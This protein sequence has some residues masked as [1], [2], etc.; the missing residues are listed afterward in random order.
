VQQRRSSSPGTLTGGQR[1]G[2]RGWPRPP[3]S[4]CDRCGLLPVGRWWG[5][6]CTGLAVDGL[7]SPSD[8]EVGGHDI[9]GG[10]ETVVGCCK[11][12]VVFREEFDRGVC[13]RLCGDK[14]R[15]GGR[16]LVLMRFPITRVSGRNQITTRL[17]FVTV[18][19]DYSPAKPNRIQCYMFPL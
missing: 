2:R 6:P 19:S 14:K 9:V 4:S 5:S 1:R 3:V 12:C 8:G 13:G 11:A 10:A 7:I 15:T 16:K 18:V 17:V